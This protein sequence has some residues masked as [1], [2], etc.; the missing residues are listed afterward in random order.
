MGCHRD[1]K[2]YLFSLHPHAEDLDCLIQETSLKLW[3]AYEEYDPARPFLPWALQIAYFEVLRFRKERCC[4]RQADSDDL[5]EQLAGEAPLAGQ[6]DVVHKACIRIMEQPDLDIDVS[7][8]AT[9][10]GLSKSGFRKKF[11]R[12]TGM[13][14]V[15]Y[16]QQIRIIRACEWLRQNDQSI[17]EIS[18]RLG[19]ESPFYFSR[20]FKRKTG[21]SPTAYRATQSRKNRQES[22]P[23]LP[24]NICKIVPLRSATNGDPQ[25]AV[26][27]AAG[28][29]E[30][31][32]SERLVSLRETTPKVV[33]DG[34][35][36]A[37]Q[38]VDLP[39]A[40]RR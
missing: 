8:L 7:D 6:A 2:N 38:A 35:L 36:R 29:G 9:S 26:H 18:A 17:S 16:Q 4:D 30:A 21:M 40:A 24:T 1:L 12:A 5:V 23:E 32:A 28:G 10:V 19:Y 3:Q 34:W 27:L 33:P 13:A 20:L 22:D 11:R 31:A 37:W 39:V 25:V 14:P 15:Q